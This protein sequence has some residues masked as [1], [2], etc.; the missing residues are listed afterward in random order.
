[1][2]I[3]EGRSLARDV[4]PVQTFDLYNLGAHVSQQCRAV[5]SGQSTAKVD[6]PDSL[7]WFDHAAICFI[8]SIHD[9]ICSVEAPV[10]KPVMR[11][12]IGGLPSLGAPTTT[13]FA[14]S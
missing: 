2:V 9:S 10:G 12:A 3:L 7:E 13:M 1:M 4:A 11:K 6:Y 5:R 8:M 14:R